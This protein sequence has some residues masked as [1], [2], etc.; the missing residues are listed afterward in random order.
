MANFA[1]FLLATRPKLVTS[2]KELHNQSTKY[3][4]YLV[5]TMLNGLSNKKAFQ[6]GTKMVDFVIL[7]R[8]STYQDYVPTDNFSFTGYNVMTQIEMPWRM[9][10]VYA[11]WNDAELVLNNGED[12]KTKFKNMREVKMGV[13]DQSW[14]EGQEDSLW[15]TPDENAMELG[16]V[17]NGAENAKPYSLRCFI[18]DDGLAP[19]STNGGVT[20]AGGDWTNVMTINPSTKANWRNQYET[21]ESA[22]LN[23]KLIPAF[24]RMYID[25]NWESPETSQKY[26]EDTKLNKLKILASRLGYVKLVE[27]A[28]ARNDSL[29]PRYDLGYQ[30]GKVTYAGIPINHIGALDTVDATP[31]ASGQFKYRWFNFNYIYPI[32]HTKRY[33]HPVDPPI[34]A[35]QPFNHVTIRDTYRN[36]WCMNRRAQGIVRAA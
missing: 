24:D 17:M 13:M 5:R 34:S 7:D 33:M 10:L 21:Y 31:D 36:L 19:S 3:R 14:W 11:T 2:T 18:T 6:G 22:A 15:A 29:T 16:D 12:E 8:V 25:V 27:L 4:T 28:T 20:G 1:D 9:S 30:N 26:M 32:Y 35:S 23:L